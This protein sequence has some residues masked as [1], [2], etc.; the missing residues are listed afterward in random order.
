[1]QAVLG[2][3]TNINGGSRSCTTGIGKQKGAAVR[4]K[5]TPR[6]NG[7]QSGII[8]PTDP[9]QSPA[10]NY[11]NESLKVDPTPRNQ[12][13]LNGPAN[14]DRVNVSGTASF[15]GA[16][17]LT[18]GPNY[19]PTLG[20]QMILVNAAGGRSGTMANLIHTPVCDQYTIVLVYSSTAAI[21]LV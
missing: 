21:A 17:R 7:G 11:I 10:S 2:G 12:N 9:R 6:G 14:T 4:G 13:D 18:L 8:Q 15:G 19:L 20:E 16:V 3:L 1:N 5:G